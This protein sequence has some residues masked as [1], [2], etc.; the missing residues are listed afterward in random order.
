MKKIMSHLHGRWGF[1]AA[2]AVAGCSPTEPAPTGALVLAIS[3]SGADV[4]PDGYVVR[5]GSAASR[6][7][8]VNDRFT[9]NGIATGDYVVSLENMAS[10]CAVT[11]TGSHAVRI[12]AAL[13]ARDSFDVRCQAIPGNLLVSVQTTGLDLDPDRGRDLRGTVPSLWSQP[14]DRLQAGSPLSGLGF[15][16]A[17]RPEPGASSASKPNRVGGSRAPSCGPADPPDLGP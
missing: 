17:G 11:R 7:V 2:F 16:W 10:N 3:T 13:P 5:V 14:Q 1:L 6:Q 12:D 9:W 4:D 8:Q 15:G